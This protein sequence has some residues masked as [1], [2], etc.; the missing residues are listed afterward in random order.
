VNKRIGRFL[1]FPDITIGTEGNI[2]EHGGRWCIG[3]TQT[4]YRDSHLGN[5]G[6]I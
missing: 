6:T 3:D 2:K 5:W 1:S 4:A